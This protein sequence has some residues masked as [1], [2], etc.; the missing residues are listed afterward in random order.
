MNRKVRSL[1]EHLCYIALAQVDSASFVQLLEGSFRRFGPVQKAVLP[2]N[3]SALEFLLPLRS[4]TTRYL[5]LE[6]NGW[7]VCISD[8]IGENC[9]IDVY[10]LSRQTNCAALAAE[11]GATQRSFRYLRN[12]QV[13]R[14]VNCYRDGFDWYF[15]QMGAPLD[16]EAVDRY[17]RQDRAERLTPDLVVHYLSRCSDIAFPLDVRHT[18]FSSIHGVQRSL[19][20]LR[21]PLEQFYVDDED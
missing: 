3:E 18:Q 9:F 10:A 7:C 20:S 5:I 21:A 8:M 13:Q 11:F 1:S 12:G 17:H 16:C 2:D 4:F 15:D 19:D 14:A 6:T